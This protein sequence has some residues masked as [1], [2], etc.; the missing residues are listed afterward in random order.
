MK[1]YKDIYH[2]PLTSD[3]A[4]WIYDDERQFV[5]QFEFTNSLLEHNIIQILNGLEQPT[6][7]HN[8]IYFEET[9]Y[10]SEDGKNYIQ[11][12]GW[13]NLIGIGGHNLPPKEAINIQNTFAEFIVNKLNSHD[14]PSTNI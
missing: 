8:F 1:T 6:K 5:A 7:P 3:M 2:F 10:I 14:K 13:G 9:G 4:G 12:R 11:I